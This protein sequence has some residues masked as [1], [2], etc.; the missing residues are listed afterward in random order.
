LDHASAAFFSDHPSVDADVQQTLLD[1]WCSE[2]K[3][4][5]YRPNSTAHL[6]ARSEGGH[7]VAK[8]E[9]KKKIV[10]AY[11]DGCYGL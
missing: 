8:T 10:R 1:Q 11:I 7:I 9:G 5:A 4:A 2:Q 6:P 3:A